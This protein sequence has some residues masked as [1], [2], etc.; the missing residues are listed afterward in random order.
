M[1]VKLEASRKKK[2]L[3]FA[4]SSTPFTHSYLYTFIIKP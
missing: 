2:K 4:C 3:T 1:E